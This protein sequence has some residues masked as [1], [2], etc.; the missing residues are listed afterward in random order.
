[1]LPIKKA[2]KAIERIATKLATDKTPGENKESES[3]QKHLVKPPR[4]DFLKTAVLA[5]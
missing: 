4:R 1:M 2:I 5:T 3:K